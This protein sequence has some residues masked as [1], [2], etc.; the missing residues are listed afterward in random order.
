MEACAGTISHAVLAS[1]RAV[2][3]GAIAVQDAAVQLENLVIVQ[4]RVRNMGGGLSIVFPRNQP[5]VRHCTFADNDLYGCDIGAATATFQNCIFWGNVSSQITPWSDTA[6]VSYCC[7]EGGYAGAG[8][9]DSNP[10]F[11]AAAMLNYDIAADSPC[12]DS[13]MN[14]PAVT[15]DCIGT[16]RPYGPAWDMGAY[17]FVP[18]PGGWGVLGLFTIYNLRLAIGRRR[19]RQCMNAPC[20]SL[21]NTRSDT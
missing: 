5:L 19:R 17:E 21:S 1:N 9:I 10:V 15:N 14:L 20:Q 18:E 11:V 7:V 16:P 4:N 2:N 8:N 6:M 12:R 13:G 3:G